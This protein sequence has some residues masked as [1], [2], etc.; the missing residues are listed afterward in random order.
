M[1][2]VYGE[3]DSDGRALDVNDLAGHGILVVQPDVV[4]LQE[5]FRRVRMVFFRRG[6][7]FPFTILIEHQA[8]TKKK[9]RCC[10]K[11]SQL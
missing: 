2:P 7:L 5:L 11:P 8:S 9:S 3:R 4:N 10:A 1:S 6:L